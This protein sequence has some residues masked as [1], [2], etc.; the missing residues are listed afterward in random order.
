MISGGLWNYYRDEIDDV[1]D[2]ASD[3]KS[4]EYKKNS[5]KTP[6]QPGNELDAN[7]PSVPDLNVE[8]TIPLNMKKNLIYQWQKTVYWCNIIVT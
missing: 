1:D 3:G 4:F 6:A 2:N 7:R 8:V 5:T